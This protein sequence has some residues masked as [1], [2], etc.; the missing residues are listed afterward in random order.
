M[1]AAFSLF[2]LIAAFT[3]FIQGNQNRIYPVYVFSADSVYVNSD[4]SLIIQKDSLLSVQEKLF[5]GKT[6][7]REK[8]GKCHELYNPKEFRVKK[9]K[10]NLDEMKHKAGLNKKQYELIFAYLS[11]NCRK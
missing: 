10:E 2:L 1:K 11:A 7:Y 6:L 8:C 5:D 3:P 4:D 9:W